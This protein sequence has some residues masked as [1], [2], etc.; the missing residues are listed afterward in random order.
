MGGDHSFR[1]G[2]YWRDNDGYN[3]SHT[4]GNA[5]ARFP[6]SAELANANDC[7]TLA[8][9][10]QM[11]LTR[12]GQTEYRLTN[13]SVYGQDTITQGR[14]TLQLGVRYDRNHDQALA[15]SVAANPLR[16]DV[17]PAVAFAGTDP[18]IIF[19]NFSPRLGF[20]FNVDG[21]GK[22]IVHGNYAM[23]WGQ[24]GTGGVASQVN[25]VTRVSIRYPWV[26]LNHDTFVQ[27]NEIQIPNNNIANLLALTGNWNPAAPGSPTTAN[28]I[29]PNLK[30]DKT[31]EFILGLDHEVGAG[32]AVGANY[33]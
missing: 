13:V 14:A 6:T 5:V 25:P 29:D 18:G 33:I 22:N 27:P 2:G 26:D 3:S 19:N 4:P 1:L 30:N 20:S 23:Y 21:T 16:P 32:F 24:V 11:Q 15:S 12:D 31:Q 17:L 10:C 7:A 28:T 9:G 8:V